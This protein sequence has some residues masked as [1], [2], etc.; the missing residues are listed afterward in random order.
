MFFRHKR[1]PTMEQTDTG[2]NPN[3]QVARSHR[4]YGTYKSNR[5]YRNPIARASRTQS[6]WHPCRGAWVLYPCSGG[7]AAL[8][9]RLIGCDPYGIMEPGLFLREFAATR[10]Y[11]ANWSDGFN[12]SV[13]VAS[14]PPD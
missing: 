11:K 13:W 4:S 14:Q 9:H 3:A 1:T 2:S 7:V 10:T 6:R 5:S 8:N 12:P